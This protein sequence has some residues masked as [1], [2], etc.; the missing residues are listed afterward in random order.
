MTPQVN[1]RR[2]QILTILSVIVSVLVIDSW[3][4]I[5]EVNYRTDQFSELQKSQQQMVTLGAELIG[6]EFDLV[7]SDLNYFSNVLYHQN[8][9]NKD[10][11]GM[12]DQLRGL[13]TQRKIYDSVRLV[14]SQGME[15]INVKRSAAGAIVTPAKQHEN[16]SD[17]TIFKQAINLSKG[18]LYV[19]ALT[20][21]NEAGLIIEP[22]KPLISFATPVYDLNNKLQGVMIIDYLAATILNNVQQF[23][24]NLEGEISLLNSHGYY[25]SNC[26]ITKQWGFINP[27]NPDHLFSVQYPDVWSA[28][29]RKRVQ[30][31]N[32]TG[33]FTF[34]KIDL[35]TRLREAN[36]TASPIYMEEQSWYLV[37]MLK[38]EG[39]DH[40]K[41]ADQSIHLVHDVVLLKS[42]ELTIILIVACLIGLLMFEYQQTYHRLEYYSNYDAMTKVYNRYAG[43]RELRKLLMSD[44]KRKTTLSICFL[45]VD[46]LKAINDAFGHDAGDELIIKAI[47]I[48]KHQIRK[49]D[50]I[51]KLGGDEFLIVFR[52]ISEGPA[53]MIWQ[54]INQEFNQYSTQMHL[55]YQ[56]SVSHG[57][58]TTTIG[59]RQEVEDVVKAADQKMYENKRRKAAN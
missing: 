38:R 31:L 56:I 19:T 47:E 17:L 36:Q 30:L 54:R 44:D 40:F 18:D 14:N 42:G 33:L 26:D 58:V 24:N 55:P 41:F 4:V 20:L 32:T 46:D 5:K 45:D 2:S 16:I 51:I 43:F 39:P 23:N 25:L 59:S 12:I 22:H 57:I 15:V 21:A 1:R 52:G 37:A 34:T 28:M 7:L 50:F 53:E 8:N 49:E 6:Q 35:K 10:K 3:V 11:Q 9:D 13:V 48:I 27:I 29:N